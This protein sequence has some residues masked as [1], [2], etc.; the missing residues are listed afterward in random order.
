MVVDPAASDVDQGFNPNVKCCSYLPELW[1]FLV[2]GLLDDEHA[3]PAGRASIEARIDSGAGVTPLCLGQTPTYRAALPS[4]R[5]PTTAA[6][7][8]M[9][10]R[11]RRAGT[12]ETWELQVGSMSSR[13]LP[14]SSDVK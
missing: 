14:L 13:Y 12:S 7:R 11:R 10:W 5:W 2:G 3:D 9:R 4:A 8:D 6:R 1:N